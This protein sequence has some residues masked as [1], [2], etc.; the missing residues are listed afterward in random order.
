MNIHNSVLTYGFA[1]LFRK[2]INVLLFVMLSD[3]TV[4]VTI[5]PKFAACFFWKMKSLVLKMDL[6]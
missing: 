2:K 6:P 3:A 4:S 1:Y 5:L